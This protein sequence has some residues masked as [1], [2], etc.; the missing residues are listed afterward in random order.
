[1]SQFLR[2]CRFFVGNSSFSELLGISTLVPYVGFQGWF[3]HIHFTSECICG[4]CNQSSRPSP[5]LLPWFCFVFFG[6]FA[7]YW[8]MLVAAVWLENIDCLFLVW[9]ASDGLIFVFIEM[10]VFLVAAIL[11]ARFSFSQGGVM[12]MLKS[13]SSLYFWIWLFLVQCSDKYRWVSCFSES[14]QRIC[15]L[16]LFCYAYTYGSILLLFTAVRLNATSL[17]W[18]QLD[19]YWSI[20]WPACIVI[21]SYGC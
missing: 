4:L 21:V 18:A 13:A 5:G 19:L 16:N 17:C 8:P 2:P 6:F 11:E 12:L 20:L 9:L 15:F 7:E 10:I 14:C 3:M 1:M